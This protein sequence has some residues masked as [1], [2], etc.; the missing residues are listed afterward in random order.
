M[1]SFL[2][3]IDCYKKKN[4]NQTLSEYL[5]AFNGTATKVLI[6]QQPIV[7]LITLPP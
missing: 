7:P 1:T 6:I 4:Y 5:V 3:N 2:Q